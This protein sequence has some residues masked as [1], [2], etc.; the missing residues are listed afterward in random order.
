MN[1][2]TVGIMN[3]IIVTTMNI[4]KRGAVG[5]MLRRFTVKRIKKY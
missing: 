1:E 2:K 4:E 3:N 5:T